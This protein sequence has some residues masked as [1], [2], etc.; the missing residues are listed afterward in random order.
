VLSAT[1]HPSGDGLITGG[2]DG[3]LVWSRRSG[4]EQLADLK[5]KWI[6]AVTA[7]PVSGLV[8]VAA[9]REA[10]VLDTADKSF[11]HRFRHERAVAGLAFEPKGRRLA[12]ATYGGV[13]LWY[14][15][16]ADQKPQM[17]KWPGAHNDVVISPDGRFIISAMQENA[18]HGWRISDAKDMRMAGYPTK[19]RSMVFLAKGALLATSGAPGLVVWPFAG[20][21]GPMGKEAIEIGLDES[22]MVTHCGAGALAMRVAAGL[23]DGR[24]WTAELNGERQ[25]FIRAEKSSPISAVAVSDDGRW[26]AWGDEAGEAGLSEAQA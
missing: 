16:V 6:D 12:T 17:L 9:G 20:S 7:S 26:I 21:N 11:E 3:K 1:V 15:K 8:A 18:L 24:V 19:I 10:V 5:G 2:D 22:T 14:A 4:A 13:M 23:A 25:N